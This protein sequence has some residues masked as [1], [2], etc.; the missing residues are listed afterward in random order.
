[1][2]LVQYQRDDEQVLASP[3]QGSSQDQ[4]LPHMVCLCSGDNDSTE[5][6]EEEYILKL[7]EERQHQADADNAAYKAANLDIQNMTEVQAL[8][9][10]KPL[11]WP[12]ACMKDHF[13]LAFDVMAQLG[14]P[15]YYY[16]SSKCH[17]NSNLTCSVT[18][19]GLA[20]VSI[21]LC[22]HAQSFV[23]E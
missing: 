12:C 8:P 18:G 22:K 13:A 15:W 1:M 21:R 19:T 17:S 14:S 7:A 5:H 10:Y 4:R 16:D 3:L 23:A 6:Y 2:Q 20:A 11:P 9:S